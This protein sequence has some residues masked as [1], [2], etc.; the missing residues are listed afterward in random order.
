MIRLFLVFTVL[1]SCKTTKVNRT[2]C[3]SFR[4]ERLAS[5]LESDGEGAY[6]FLHDNLELPNGW[7]TILRLD[8]YDKEHPEYFNSIKAKYNLYELMLDSLVD[9]SL[10]DYQLIHYTEIVDCF[11]DNSHGGYF[12]GSNHSRLVYDVRTERNLKCELMTG[13]CSNIRFNLDTLGYLKDFI[14]TSFH[15]DTIMSQDY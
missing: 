15:P 11:G 2:E 5:Y 12:K 1:V 3:E 9:S 13:N 14:G 7:S 8:K 4:L 6:R 10:S